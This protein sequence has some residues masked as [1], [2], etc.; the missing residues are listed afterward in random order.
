MDADDD[1]INPLQEWLSLK[2][3]WNC[4]YICHHCCAQKKDYAC[5]PGN[6]E[7]RRDRRDFEDHACRKS[8]CDRMKSFCGW[9]FGI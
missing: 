5:V 1:G 7:A 2:V 8:E 3:G 4:N 9:G 6:L